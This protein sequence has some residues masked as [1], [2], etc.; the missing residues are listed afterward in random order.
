[1]GYN[2]PTTPERKSLVSDTFFSL[3]LFLSLL[4][5]QQFIFF[6]LFFS[7]PVVF[8]NPFIRCIHGVPWNFA[9]GEMVL[10]LG[11][12]PI[13]ITWKMLALILRE[14]FEEIREGKEGGVKVRIAY[15]HSVRATV[16]GS[17]MR[18][19]NE[20]LLYSRVECTTPP[21]TMSVGY[22]HCPHLHCENVF[23]FS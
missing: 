21:I 9:N 22:L 4:H 6:F 3:F 13:H 7:L 16:R 11:A 18:I 19:G 20:V 12:P 23:S 10:A 17:T 1:M 5:E 14:G 8:N 15:T 2:I